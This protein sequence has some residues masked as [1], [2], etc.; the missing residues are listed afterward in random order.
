[1]VSAADVETLE[2][3]CSDVVQVAAG[4][5]VELRLL[6]GRHDQALAACLPLAHSIAPRGMIA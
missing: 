4:C 3:A 1:V 2:R 6:N 5:G